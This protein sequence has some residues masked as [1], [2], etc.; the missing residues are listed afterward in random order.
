[1]GLHKWLLRIKV[2]LE[3]PRTKLHKTALCI[4]VRLL[5]LLVVPRRPSF[6]FSGAQ[7]LCNMCFVIVIQRALVCSF[8]LQSMSPTSA[9]PRNTFDYQTFFTGSEPP[10]AFLLATE[11]NDKTRHGRC[12]AR[13]CQVRGSP[14]SS[15]LP[16]NHPSA[17]CCSPKTSKE[18]VAN[19]SAQGLH[20]SFDSKTR[21]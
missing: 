14:S 17:R 8:L 2:L 5:C 18:A 7:L 19:T 20:G 4:V 3:K 10:S 21:L 9:P 1:M 12:D 11:N 16:P 15:S 6:W 13:L